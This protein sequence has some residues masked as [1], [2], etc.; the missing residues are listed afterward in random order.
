MRAGRSPDGLQ[1]LGRPVSEAYLSLSWVKF[2][3]EVCLDSVRHTVPF[4]V[5]ASFY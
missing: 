3:C 5:K 4:P 1:I 2:G